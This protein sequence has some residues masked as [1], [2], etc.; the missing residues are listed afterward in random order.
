[1]GQEN[2][3]I[4][5]DT[6]PQTLSE[7]SLGA[8]ADYIKSGQCRRILVMTGAGISTAAGIPDFRS[9]NTGLY[10]NLARLN[11]PYAE[12]VFDISYFR[13]HPEPFYV[14]AQELYPG[15]FYPTVSHVF[16]ALLAAKGLLFHLF[17]QNIDC[18]EREAGVPGDLIVEAHGSFATQRCIECK[19]PYPDAEM[20]EHVKAGQVPRCE[21]CGGLV[22]PDIVFFGEQL[23]DVFRSKQHYP[24]QADMVLILGTSLTVHPFA[25]LPETVGEEAPRVLFNLER[26]GGIG[27]RADDV[28]ELGDCDAGVRRLADALGWREELETKWRGVVGDEEA[29]RQ[30]KGAKQRETVL[31]D[32]VDKLAEEVEET[33][34]IEEK[35]RDADDRHSSRGASDEKDAAP[36]GPSSVEAEE[37][38]AA[39]KEEEYVDT[40]EIGRAHV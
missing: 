9:P 17:T 13:E 7:R 14:L 32:E 15:K 6:P 18:L 27:S 35:D 34:N 16:I 22:K 1:M 12:A 19:E 2:S 33:L 40:G 36:E 26:V 20:L 38:K 30:L 37:S 24:A 11:L 29:E 39:T 23:P 31:G 28:L 3:V 25:S 10:A 8:V 5:D 21:K 4:S